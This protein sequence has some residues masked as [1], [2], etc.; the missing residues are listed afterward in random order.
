MEAGVEAAGDCPADSDLAPPG[1]AP[2]ALKAWAV[3]RVQ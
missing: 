3:A 2:Q 1:Q